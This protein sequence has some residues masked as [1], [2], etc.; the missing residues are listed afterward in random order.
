MSTVAKALNVLFAVAQTDNRIGVTE[1][2]HR[3][4]LDKA[5]VHRSLKALEAYALIEQCSETRRYS[6]GLG[7]VTLAG[8][9]LRGMS[10]A[11]VA[12]PYLS[13]LSLVT[14][15]TVQLSVRQGDNVLY[16]AVV[17]SPQPI[18]VASDVGSLGPLHAT[19]AGKVF[20]ANST[21][22][23]NTLAARLPLA[24][25]TPATLCEIDK[26]ALDL[27]GVRERGWSVDNEE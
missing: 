5:T 17:E 25:H 10:V 1:L 11:T 8:S 9:K 23:L 13:R 20:L 15:E 3:T 26:L 24:R 14:G 19:A 2:C 16:L 6:L 22:S 12:Q 27:E 4:G 18:R 7:T 21:E